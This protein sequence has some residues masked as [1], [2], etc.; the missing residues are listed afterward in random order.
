MCLLQMC[1]Y[2][3]LCWPKEIYEFMWLTQAKWVR[4]INVPRLA[5]SSKTTAC[6]KSHIFKYVIVCLCTC[7][8]MEVLMRDYWDWTAYKHWAVFQNKKRFQPLFISKCSGLCLD[9]PLSVKAVGVSR[10]HR[11]S[12]CDLRASAINTQQ[13]LPCLLW[14]LTIVCTWGE[15]H[16]VATATDHPFPYFTSFSNSADVYLAWVVCALLS[17]RQ[18]YCCRWDQV[19]LRK[20]IPTN[21]L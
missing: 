9:F 15:K 14:D 1:G 10:G 17:W 3:A 18:F 21:I 13:V 2:L 20:Q 6:S 4:M 5:T 8:G 11:L 19:A 12:H 7:R 16:T